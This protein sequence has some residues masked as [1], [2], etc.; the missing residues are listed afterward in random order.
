MAKK[1]R[2]TPD[3][4]QEKHSRRT[5]AALED[6]RK[7]IDRVTEAPGAKAA[8][9]Q[10]KMRSH[11]VEAIDSGKWSRRVSS[12][13]LDEWKAD[14]KEKGVG[15]VAA[16]LDRAEGKVKAFA[17]ELIEHENALLSE[18]D[19]MPDLTLEDSIGRATAWIRGMAEFERS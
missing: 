19:R 2:V 12:V 17:A 14:M 11:L 15:R 9:Q 8:A 6:M 13:S 5:K 10:D 16:G 1:V 18:I 4:F 7:G 3:E